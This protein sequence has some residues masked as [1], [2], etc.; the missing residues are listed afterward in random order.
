M[1]DAADWVAAAGGVIGAIGGPA[2]MW[3]AWQQHQ[4]QKRRRNAPPEELTDLLLKLGRIGTAAMERY[5]RA[6]WWRE[7]GGGPAIERIS[8]LQEIVTDFELLMALTAVEGAYLQAADAC[9][10]DG[11]PPEF[12]VNF[13]TVQARSASELVTKSKEAVQRI[14]QLS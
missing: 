5:K 13:A 3:A 12:V 11:T 2:G 7:S 9:T 6:D 10:V 1:S 4:E 14:R 8:E